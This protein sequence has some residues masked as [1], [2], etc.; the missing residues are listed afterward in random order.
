MTEYL[1]LDDEI[2]E[3]L[4]GRLDAATRERVERHLAECAECRRLRDAIS[5]VKTGAREA[6]RPGRPPAELSAAIASALDREAQA[7][8]SPRRLRPAW[9]LAAAAVTVA[10]LLAVLLRRPDLPARAAHDFLRFRDG[11]LPLELLTGDTQRLERFFAERGIPFRTRVFDLG[12]MRYRLVGGRVQT[13]AG[14]P[15]ALFVYRGPGDRILICEMYPGDTLE[16]PR[17]ARRVEH[18][19]IAFFVFHRKGSTQVFWQ[20]GDVTCV[21]VSDAPPEEVLSLAFAKAMRV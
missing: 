21:L 20:E 13:L 2:Q 19:G 8:R 12:M 7:F 6:L 10:L 1:H 5:A 16:L 17:A 11:A 14:R 3:L 9:A 4:D 18:D 15:A